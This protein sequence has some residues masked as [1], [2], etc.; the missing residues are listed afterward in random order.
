[1]TTDEEKREQFLKL[2]SIMKRLRGE[3]GCPWDKEQ[4]YEALKRYLIEESYEVFAAIDEK[5]MNHVCEELGD[6][7]LQVVFYAQM[8]QE[9]GYFDM[10]DVLKSINEKMIRRHPHVFGD[11]DAQN[12]KEVL[13][14]WELIKQKEGKKKKKIM[15]INQNLPALLLAQKAQEKAARVGFDW[16]DIQGAYDKLAEELQEFKEAQNEEE[17]AEELGDVLFSLVNI[18]RMLDMDSENIMRKA[19]NKFIRRF[20]DMEQ[21][22]EQ[23]GQEWQEYDLASLDLLW[24]SAKAKE[25]KEKGK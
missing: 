17:K 9:D 22:L 4:N 13:A 19:T 2:L 18:A 12:S 8:G 25:K 23:N 15:E 5:D 21:V 16:P 1:M 11:D 7:L 20:N 14:K 3:N 24:E 6:V 10:G